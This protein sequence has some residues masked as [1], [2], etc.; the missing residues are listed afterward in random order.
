MGRLL[1]RRS[2]TIVPSAGSEPPDMLSEDP[3]PE[4]LSDMLRAR[5][6]MERLVGEMPAMLREVF[7]LFELEELPVAEVAAVLS[8]PIGT[9]GSRLRRARADFRARSRRLARKFT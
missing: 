9:V 4:E 7:V 6:F 8:V 1:R 5:A 2:R 3:S